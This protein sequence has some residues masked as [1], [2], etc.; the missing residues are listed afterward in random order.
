MTKLD[1]V[2]KILKLK[3]F[4]NVAKITKT[5]NG[6]LTQFPNFATS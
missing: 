4:P 2:D 6:E 1:E 3:K 5:T